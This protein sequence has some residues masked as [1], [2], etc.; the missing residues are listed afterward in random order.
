M[1]DLSVIVVTY[2]SRQH[3]G[4]CIDSLLSSK[5]NARKE[6]IVVDNSSTDGGAEIAM[7]YVPK[8][9]LL[10]N[11][12]NLGFAKANNIGINA[13]RGRYL[14]FLNPDTSV[15][16]NSLDKLLNFISK[17]DNVGIVGPKLVNPDGSLQHSCRRFYSIRTILM[18]RTILGTI[19]P[20]S[21][22][23]SNHL[24]LDYGHEDIQEVDWMIG[25][26]LMIPRGTIESLG[27]FDE[28][29]YLY[30]ED[31]DICFRAKEAGYRVLYYPEATVMHHHKR[32]SA[33]RFNKTTYF[34]ISSAVK[35][36]QRHGWAI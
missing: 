15:E 4:R 11:K 27:G 33:K 31:V 21:E 36:F 25:A 22:H 16:R 1:V 18:R 34:H 10:K 35:Y 19:F 6:I 20:K 26:C 12:V 32:E 5:S 14:L 9:K 8:V 3:I 23:L 24:M 29:Y 28:R 17:E 13:S 30:F 2:N 7:K